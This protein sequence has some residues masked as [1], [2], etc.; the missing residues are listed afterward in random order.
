MLVPGFIL[1]GAFL[2]RVCMF[3]LCL[4]G[5]CVCVCVRD[6]LTT[7]LSRLDWLCWEILRE[8]YSC[9]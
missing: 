4:C 8:G 9:W 7:M 6:V 2:C 5:I 1:V 3:F